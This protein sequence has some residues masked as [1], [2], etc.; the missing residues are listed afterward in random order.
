M[1]A[2]PQAR[3]ASCSRVRARSATRASRCNELRR[4]T[5]RS[6]RTQHGAWLAVPPC[7]PLSLSAQSALTGNTPCDKP[8]ARAARLGDREQQLARLLADGRVERGA[9]LGQRA[10]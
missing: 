9:P 2:A 1:L 10:L 3:W 6:Q 7:A 4:R 5:P 8:W